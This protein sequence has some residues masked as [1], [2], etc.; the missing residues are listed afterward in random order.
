MLNHLC[1]LFPVLKP[2][3]LKGIFMCSCII[4]SLGE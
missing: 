4:F 3:C 2:G 1:I